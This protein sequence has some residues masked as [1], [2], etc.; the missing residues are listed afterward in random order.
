MACFSRIDRL[1]AFT[2]F[3]KEQPRRSHLGGC[4]PVAKATVADGPLTHRFGQ[5]MN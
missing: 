3:S 2:L 1:T 5:T 4:G